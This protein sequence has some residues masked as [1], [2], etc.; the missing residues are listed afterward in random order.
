MVDRA[1][2]GDPALPDIIKRAVPLGRTARAHEVSDMVVFL[3]SART[4]YVTGSA[5]IVDGGTTLQ[6][7]I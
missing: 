6:V 5:V 1:V 3:C 2:A 4:S 7:K